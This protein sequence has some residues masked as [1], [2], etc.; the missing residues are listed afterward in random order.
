MRAE[1]DRGIA[2]GREQHVI[3]LGDVYYTGAEKEY[4]K[5]FLPYWPV[6]AGEDIGSYTL[7]G[8]H[9][10][11]RGG[12]AYYDT[13][14]KDPRFSRQQGK[15]VFALRSPS[16][17]F[18]GL[19]TGYE[20]AALYG[21]QPA[22]IQQQRQAGGERR[23]ALLTH[24][25]YFSSYESAGEKLRN[26]IGPLIGEKPIDA[27]FWAHEHRC[28]VYPAREGINFST[29]VGH[30]GIPEYLIAAEGKPYPPGLK[31]EYRLKHG[32]G[33]E[34]WNT[35]GFVVLELDGRAMKVRYINEHGTPHHTE[36]IAG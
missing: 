4:K 3:H 28:L 11:F 25:Q 22:W 7:V 17:Q 21:E 23:T 31:Y 30:S 35:F 33:L 13:C 34:P 12:H 24:H 1:L 6:H 27:W 10:M 19:D 20:D 29:C 15:S 14:L 18:L 9:D 36:E 26:T 8:N 5:R 32:D 16:W 2:D